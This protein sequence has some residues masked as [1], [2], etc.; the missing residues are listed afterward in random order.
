M[1]RW[2]WP[3]IPL[4]ILFS[5][6]AFSV[7]D[8]LQDLDQSMQGMHSIEMSIR[9]RLK[10]RKS[11]VFA[12]RSQWAQLL[13]FYSDRSYRPIWYARKGPVLNQSLIDQLKEHLQNAP[14]S[15]L[16]RYELK[17]YE[18]HIASVSNED[19]TEQP[20]SVDSN[21]PA[22]PQYQQVEQLQK[23]PK[24]KP[25]RKK[26]SKDERSAWYELAASELLLIQAQSL[27]SGQYAPSK[28]DKDW[29]IKP[30]KFNGVAF[31]QRFANSR[32]RGFGELDALEPVN[33]EYHKLKE[34]LKHYREL[35]AKGGWPEI[36]VNMPTLKPGMS[37]DIVPAVRKRLQAE[38]PYDSSVAA[39]SPVYD[40]DLIQAVKTFQSSYGLTSD[41][42]IGRKTRVALRMP[43]EKRIQ[44][45]LASMERWRWMP[46][47][48]QGRYILVNLPSYYLNLYE[49]GRPVW[50]TRV[51]NGSKKHPSPSINMTIKQ[52]KVNPKWHVPNSIAV[53]EIIPKL[54]E[55]PD[56][57]TKND[58]VVVE[59]GTTNII[60]P[61]TIPWAEFTDP[62]KFPYLIRQGSGD[63][64]A[65]GR[66]KFVM[67]NRH[68]IY[69]HDTP[70]KHLFK[71]DVRAFS[72]G[73]VRVQSPYELAG[74]LLNK[75][76]PDQARLQVL[77][78]ID[79]GETQDVDLPDRIP[80]Y[81]TYFTA[82]VS[83]DGDVR[84]RRDIYGRDSF[85]SLN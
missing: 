45:I 57:L 62:K 67:P 60:D 75:D 47:N 21:A 78:R 8:P 43:V 18:E 9:K 13:E 20:A 42:I 3:F 54:L 53:K 76:Q 31:M 80:V 35:I 14:D 65:L 1:S 12:N 5:P 81:L 66:L 41:G 4:F 36:P 32:G 27:A 10:S 69:L 11:G 63:E 6:P 46:R 49:D 19:T 83:A 29:L 59:R 22:R 58:Y 17:T 51:I 84:F 77:Q 85:F 82:D 56:Y 68:H 28:A 7:F 26:L 39:D 70:T 38:K 25:K 23:K 74:I 73:C 34:L 55:D 44:S 71:R 37:S 72:H 48:L 79:Q 61:Y 40:A 50:G 16:K 33:P 64:N 30:P 52:V 15:G 2:V 24:A